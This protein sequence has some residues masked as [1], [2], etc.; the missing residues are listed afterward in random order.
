MPLSCTSNRLFASGVFFV[1]EK[2]EQQAKANAAKDAAAAAAATAAAAA[3]VGA[4]SAS[5]GSPAT[6]AGQTPTPAEGAKG[7]VR[8]FPLQTYCMG[9]ARQL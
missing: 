3:P 9:V 4:S 1:F 2:A 5:K 6:V 8:V 7:E